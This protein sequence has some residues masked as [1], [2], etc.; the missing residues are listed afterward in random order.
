MRSLKLSKLLRVIYQNQ[1]I[2]LLTTKITRALVLQKSLSF[3]KNYVTAAMPN[4][5]DA[6][7]VFAVGESFI[8]KV[9]ASYETNILQYVLIFAT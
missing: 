8:A 7:L 4:R 9:P 3:N 1:L 5:E 6:K 2:I